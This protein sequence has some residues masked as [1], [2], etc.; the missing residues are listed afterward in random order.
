M[1][2]KKKIIT[3]THILVQ[4]KFAYAKDYLKPNKLT[5]LGSPIS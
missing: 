4:Y 5:K 3:D 1:K 2:K